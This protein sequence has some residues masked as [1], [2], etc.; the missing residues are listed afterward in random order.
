MNRLTSSGRLCRSLRT[1]SLLQTP[2]HASGRTSALLPRRCLSTY[3]V[4]DADIL[5]LAKQHQHP[6]SLADLVKYNHTTLI[7]EV[8]SLQRVGVIILTDSALRQTWPPATFRALSLVFSKLYSLAVTDSTCSSPP[9]LSQP[10][11][12]CCLQPQHLEDIQHLS[13]LPLYPPPLLAL[14]RRGAPN[15]YPRR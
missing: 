3:N 13:P 4:T 7:S 11:V 10:S 14:R 6:L 12:H 5:T 15:F 8:T 2:S 9:G 1:Y